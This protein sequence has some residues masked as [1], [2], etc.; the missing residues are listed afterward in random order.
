MSRHGW[1][2]QTFDSVNWEAVRTVRAGMPL[3]LFIRTSKVMHGWL[4]VMHMQAHT[5]GCAQC[6]G[7]KCPDETIEHLYRCTNIEAKNTREATLVAVRKKGIGIGIPRVVME[8]IVRALYEYTNELPMTIPIHPS[9]AQAIRSQQEI[10][11]HLLPRGFLT[12]AWGDALTDFA[13]ENPERKI[14]GLLKMLWVD[15]TDKLWQ[16]QNDIAHKKNNLTQQR[17]EEGWAARLKWFLGHPLTLASSDRFLLDYEEDDIQRM[18]SRVRKKRVQQLEIA[19]EAFTR[20]RALRS[21]GQSMITDFFHKLTMDT[22]DT[23]VTDL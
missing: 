15:F 2:N 19:L 1:S 4:P 18:S 12:K 16:C 22:P 23:I 8:A 5:T 21:T 6:P 20:E 17:L 7:C 11:I 9:L 10:G 14:S 3:S 13:V